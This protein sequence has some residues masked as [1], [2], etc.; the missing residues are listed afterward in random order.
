MTHAMTLFRET[1]F[2][3]TEQMKFVTLAVEEIFHSDDP[4]GAD[5]RL[6]AMEDTI[7][8]IR[9][10]IQRDAVDQAEQYG[11]MHTVNGSKIEVS[12]RTTKDYTSCGDSLYLEMIAQ[13]KSLNE[14]IKAREMM[15]ESG[16]NPETGET[17]FPPKTSTTTFLKYTFA[18]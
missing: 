13:Q 2:T 7:K 12:S 6:K 4:L 17:Y 18:K 5:M 9:K 14:Q 1:P 8:E 11:K 16:V 10:Q 3:K 15:I